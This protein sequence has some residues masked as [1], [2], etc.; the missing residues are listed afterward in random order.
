[1]TTV[2]LVIVILLIVVLI[3]EI[4]RLSMKRILASDKLIY[5]SLI[6]VLATAS[7][8]GGNAYISFNSEGVSITYIPEDEDESVGQYDEGAQV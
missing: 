2:Q 4:V 5:D 6:R 7:K 1:M 8:L 3:L